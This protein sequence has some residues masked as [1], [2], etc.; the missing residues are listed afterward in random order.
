LLGIEDCMGKAKEGIGS[1]SIHEEKSEKRK[2]GT[3]RPHGYLVPPHESLGASWKCLPLP[4]ATA[5]F[6][7]APH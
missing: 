4:R 3:V 7:C 1:K 6:T 5:R 2:Q